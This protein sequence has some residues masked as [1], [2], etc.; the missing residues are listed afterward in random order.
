M[1]E[2]TLSKSLTVM[3]CAA[4]I[5]A[6]A[7]CA[8]LNLRWRTGQEKVAGLR[9]ELAASNAIWNGINDEKLVLQDELK[10]TREAL[11]EAEI[12]CEESA[13]KS[14]T[15]RGQLP[16]LKQRRDQLL[17]AVA[18]RQAIDKGDTAALPELI[19]MGQEALR[20]E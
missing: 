19:R 5:A 20:G 7:L 13:A 16:A 1:K 6:V 9:E 14:E 15:I 17:A 2:R 4:M 11:R 8:G 18:L 10:T 3:V 12:A